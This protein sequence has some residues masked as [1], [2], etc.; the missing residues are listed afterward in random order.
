MVPNVVADEEDDLK[1]IPSPNQSLEPLWEL[2]SERYVDGLRHRLS[3]ALLKKWRGSSFSVDF[4][5][6]C[7]AEALL[8][9]ANALL[10]GR[11]IKNL[12]AYALKS[13]DR[14]LY[15]ALS[16]Q[17]VLRDHERHVATHLHRSPVEERVAEDRAQREASALSHALAVARELLPSVGTG[18]VIEV[19]EVFLEAVEHGVPDLP[20]SSVADTLGLT[21]SEV[22]SLLHRGLTRLRRAAVAHGITLPQAL[23]ATRFDA[24]Q[25][26]IEHLL[27]NPEEEHS[28]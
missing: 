9:T 12:R 13:A 21:P 4:A 10:A 15:K 20:A 17:R 3:N 18:R 16:H 14:K 28:E 25:N 7:I 26:P 19:L 5:D 1:S 24:Y 23:D 2:W 27:S 8:D 11:Q 22:R 6:D